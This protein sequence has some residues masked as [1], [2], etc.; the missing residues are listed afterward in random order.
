M[1]EEK[2][3]KSELGYVDIIQALEKLGF[4]TL[5]IDNRDSDGCEYTDRF[6]ITIER[7]SK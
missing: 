3:E 6:T 2:E 7:K 4:K 5:R 1:T